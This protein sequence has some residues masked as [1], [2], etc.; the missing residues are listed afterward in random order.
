MIDFISAIKHFGDK[1]KPF[2][3]YLQFESQYSSGWVK[4]SINRCRQMDI[5]VH[6][7]NRI[8]RIEGSILYFVQGHNLSFDRRKFVEGVQYLQTLLKVGL[9]DSLVYAFEF[10]VIMEVESPPKEYIQHHVAK[11]KEKLQMN[12]KPKDKG[13]FRWWEDSNVSNKMYDAGANVRQ[14]QSKAMQK[15]LEE[16]GWNPEGYYL[17]WEAHYKKPQ[18]L[19]HGIGLY[20]GD[21]VAP[22][23]QKVFCEDLFV[24]YQRLVPMKSLINPKDKKNCST[25]DIL[26]SAIA[27]GALN[28][29]K[30]LQDLKRL[31]YDKINSIP[32]EVLTESDKKARKRKIK[33]LLDKVQE[34][35]E[36]RWDLSDKLAEALSASPFSDSEKDKNCY[37]NN[38]TE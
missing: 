22:Q 16:E 12:E 1:D 10:G 32:E 20:L 28:E 29:G 4:Y 23:W 11:P 13:K 30:S 33:E 21:L 35:P 26:M 38:T 7:T 15:H 19:N 9:W 14:K 18:I 31:L 27:E 34:A 6:P 5:W 2:L 3:G 8:L 37:P 36:S 25:P 17:K 24:Q